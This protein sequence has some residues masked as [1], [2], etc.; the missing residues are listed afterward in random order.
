MLLNDLYTITDFTYDDAIKATITINTAH[1]IFEGHFPGMPILPG[2]CMTAIIQELLEKNENKK[3]PIRRLDQVKF[4]Q[5]VN[6][7]ENNILHITIKNQKE[8][9][10]FKFNAVIH[11]KEQVVLKLSGV[12]IV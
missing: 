9:E 1:R 8:Q 12:A 2:A 5:M 4:L 6:P 7:F 3:I 11:Q 10:H